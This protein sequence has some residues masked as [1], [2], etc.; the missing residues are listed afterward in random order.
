MAG[1]SVKLAPLGSEIGQNNLISVQARLRRRRASNP[2]RMTAEKVL[3]GARRG[4]S[5]RT[6]DREVASLGE[7][8]LAKL[9]LEG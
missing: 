6:F 3:A 9:L 7:A 4:Q 8:A 1:G 5:T 2:E